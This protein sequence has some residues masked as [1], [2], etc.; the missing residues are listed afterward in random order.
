MPKTITVEETTTIR[1]LSTC[2]AGAVASLVTQPLEV[3]KT[4]RIHSPA[5]FYRDLHKKIVQ[6]GWGQYMRGR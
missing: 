1:L 6:K 5:E 2:V 4:N 3:I